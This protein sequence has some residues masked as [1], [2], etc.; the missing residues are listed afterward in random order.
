MTTPVATGDFGYLS[1]LGIGTSSTVSTR[2]DFESETLALQETLYDFNGL[3][4][5]RAHDVSRIRPNTRSVSGTVSLQPTSVELSQIL[6][7][8]FGGTSSGT[9][10]I[11]Y[12]LA[13]TLFSQYVSVDRG[14]AVHTY[15]GVYV[16]RATFSATQG[17]PLKVS[18]DL[19]GIDETVNAAGSFPSLTL[20]TTTK[21]FLFFDLALTIGA[22]QQYFA[23]DFE[24]T[25]DN[26]LDTNRFFNSPTLTA[27]Y[28]QDR[29]VT[30]R[31]RLPYGA[32]SALYGAGSS[33]VAM[34]ATFTYG[35]Q[36]LTFT[37]GT[38][39]FAR[40]AVPVSG[41]GEIMLP[42]EADLMKSGNNLE[43]T[44]TLKTS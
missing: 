6:A 18:L 43:L 27:V 3:R 12:P 36:V 9:G 41:R 11:T 4:G 38:M 39:V 16:N 24:L 31:S 23:D 28:T 1:Q 20:D 30:F 44:T 7:W 37:A 26:A 22:S 14:A 10:T 33:G 25:I 8:C 19:L 5:T 13:D 34:N 40:S 32:A 42:I 2:L 29:K 15:S 17:G 21:P 35:T